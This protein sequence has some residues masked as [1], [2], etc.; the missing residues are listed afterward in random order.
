MAPPLW[1]VT[2]I[3]GTTTLEVGATGAAL[4]A[5]AA[6][7]QAATASHPEVP[8]EAWLLLTVHRQDGRANLYSWKWSDGRFRELR[9]EH[10]VDSAARKARRRR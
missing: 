3:A 7:L 6:G 5:A 1:E 4:E 10:L 2:C 8:K 9:R